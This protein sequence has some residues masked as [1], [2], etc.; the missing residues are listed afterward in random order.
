MLKRK[1]AN[2]AAFCYLH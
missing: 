1:A 2:F